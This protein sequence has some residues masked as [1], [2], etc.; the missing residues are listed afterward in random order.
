METIQEELRYKTRESSQQQDEITSLYNQV[1]LINFLFLV[2]NDLILKIMDLQTKIK[3]LTIENS[4]LKSLINISAAT[5]GELATE[6][7][8]LKSKYNDCFE[9]LNSTRDEL[10]VMRCK[11]TKK[12]ESKMLKHEKQCLQAPWMTGNSFATELQFLNLNQDKIAEN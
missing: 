11:Y 1:G 12:S 4:E 5:Q 9:T 2:L 6:L 3:T 7:L 10:K 8:D